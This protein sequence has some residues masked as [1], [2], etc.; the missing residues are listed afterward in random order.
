[1]IADAAAEGG[2]KTTT[3]VEDAMPYASP[4]AKALLEA[5]LSKPELARSSTSSPPDLGTH[6]QIIGLTSRAS[7]GSLS[8]GPPNHQQIPLKQWLGEPVR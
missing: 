3:V 1:M 4:G 5:G 6:L 7:S 8:G 2:V